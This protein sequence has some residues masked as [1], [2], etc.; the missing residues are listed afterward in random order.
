MNQ[1][2]SSWAGTPRICSPCSWKHCAH[3]FSVMSTMLTER[4]R[5]Q[6][7]MSFS[8]LHF[9]HRY[10]PLFWSWTWNVTANF[11]FHEAKHFFLAFTLIELRL[12]LSVRG[13]K[14]VGRTSLW[15]TQLNDVISKQKSDWN[16]FELMYRQWGSEIGTVGYSLN[17]DSKDLSKYTIS[18]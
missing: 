10:M 9:S 7:K 1:S 17:R 2:P 5:R 14:I 8:K 12:N 11:E 16:F 4:M 6:L 13:L 3:W 15:F 18:S